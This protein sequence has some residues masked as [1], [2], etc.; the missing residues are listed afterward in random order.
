M[1]IVGAREPPGNSKQRAWSLIPLQQAGNIGRRTSP[2]LIL[3]ID[4]SK[5]LT[6]SV[7]HDEAVRG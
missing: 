4:V 1:D 5:L 7:A 3:I 6:V 2:R